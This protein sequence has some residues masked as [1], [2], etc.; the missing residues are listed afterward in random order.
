MKKDLVYD[1]NIVTS[2]CFSCKET[3]R[4]Y[5]V[6]KVGI[7]FC[8]QCI[9]NN[10]FVELTTIPAIIKQIVFFAE[11]ENQ[12]VND[13]LVVDISNLLEELQKN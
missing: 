2:E 4:L 12:K 7:T 9:L 6:Q 13:R 1:L 5:D 8:K 10:K 11:K 3:F